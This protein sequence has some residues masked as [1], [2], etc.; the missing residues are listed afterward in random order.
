MITPTQPFFMYHSNYCQKSVGDVFNALVLE[1][2]L[3]APPLLTILQKQFNSSVVV[4]L[5]G[6]SLKTLSPKTVSSWLYLLIFV[7]YVKSRLRWRMSLLSLRDS[8]HTFLTFSQ[9]K[10]KFLYDASL[11]VFHFSAQI[12]V[13]LCLFQ[14]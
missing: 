13:K 14:L 11:C 9:T 6:V 1:I 2:R 3:S 12:F 5:T 10:W 7:S 4:V 8:N